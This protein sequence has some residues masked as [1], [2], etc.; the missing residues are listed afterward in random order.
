MP[1]LE[2]LLQGYWWGNWWSITLS[3]DGHWLVGWEPEIAHDTNGEAAVEKGT[4]KAAFLDGSRV[5]KRIPSPED[6]WSSGSVNPLWLPDSRHWVVLLAGQQG[7]YAMVESL[8]VPG[9]LQKVPIGYPQGITGMSAFLGSRLLGSTGPDRILATPFYAAPSVSKGP[10][11]RISFYEFSIRPGAGIK[12]VRQYTVTLPKGPAPHNRDVALRAGEE[13]ALSPQ[14]DRLAW[15][16]HLR[17][18]PDRMTRFLSRW[19]PWLRR[20]PKGA[21]VLRTSRLDGNDIQD[22]GY[23]QIQPDEFLRWFQPYRLQWLPGGKR[24]SFLYKDA[25]WTVPAD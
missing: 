19:I 15:L 18:E 9:I 25:V 2:R 14:G 11:R 8:N 22:V 13:V 3:P 4:M 16:L 21:M 23:M 1:S 7:L 12:D 6:K 5:I 24:L 17:Q 10:Q 20:A